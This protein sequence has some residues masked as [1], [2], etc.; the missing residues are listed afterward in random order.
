[1]FRALGARLTL[2]DRGADV[3]EVAAGAVQ[4]IWEWTVAGLEAPSAWADGEYAG[5]GCHVNALQSQGSARTLHHAVVD[6]PDEWDRTQAWRT[7]INVVVS[8]HVEVGVA[9]D[10]EVHDPSVL[11]VPLQPAL[12]TLLR[13]LATRG[14]WAGSQRISASAQA[15]V[16]TE[17]VAHFVGSVLMD[18]GRTL[19]VLLFTATKEHDG[20]FM[21]E[22]TDPSLVA[23]ELCGL[24]HVYL[25]PRVEDTHKLTK[26]LGLLSA[27]DG[28]V[29]L[30]WP[31]FDPDDRPPRHPLHLRARLTTSTIL[32]IIRRIVDASARVYLE[33]TGTRTL[34]TL[35]W[36]GVG[37]DRVAEAVS[38]KAPPARRLAALTAELERSIAQT[39][40]MSQELETARIE[41]ERAQKLIAELTRGRNGDGTQWEQAGV[42]AMRSAISVADRPGRSG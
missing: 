7:T 29:R 33:P 39:E 37:R 25:M 31:A 5:D 1:M 8:D 12:L 28:A 30:Y 27:Y 32:S 14:A 20:V 22:G 9:V 24:A 11:P 3:S 34:L 21:P 15:V 13:G 10:H 2:D 35:Y 19:P 6:R 41:L 23:R 40:R 4:A 42:D 16:G 36:N 38:S 17:G 18:G 26:R